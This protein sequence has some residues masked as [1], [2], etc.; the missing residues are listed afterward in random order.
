MCRALLTLLKPPSSSQFDLAGRLS[1]AALPQLRAAPLL[2]LTASRAVFPLLLL[3]CNVSPPAG[4]W[5]PPRI[6]A[7]SDGAPLA[8]LAALAGSNGLVTALAMTGGPASAPPASRGVAA[9]ALTAW[10]V[11]GVSAG[12]ALSVLLALALQH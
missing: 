12:S 6:L 4:R 9:T 2:A 10:L 8:L 11:A 1:A 3:G 5:L 7:G